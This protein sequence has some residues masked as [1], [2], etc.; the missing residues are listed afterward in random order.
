MQLSLVDLLFYFFLETFL[1]LDI[2]FLLTKFFTHFQVNERILNLVKLVSCFQAFYDYQT[3]FNFQVKIMWLYKPISWTLWPWTTRSSVWLSP[4]ISQW[5]GTSPVSRPTI[6]S[7]KTNGPPLTCNLWTNCGCQI[8]SSTIYEGSRI[9]QNQKHQ[10]LPKTEIECTIYGSNLYLMKLKLN[11]DF[12]FYFLYIY[13][14]NLA[15]LRR[16][17][18]DN[19]IRIFLSTL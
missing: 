15:N 8:F 4:C 1:H 2:F 10:F 14:Q 17:P 16:F 5:G 19:K 11:F 13:K 6:L 9:L 3:S 7:K 12:Y 18:P